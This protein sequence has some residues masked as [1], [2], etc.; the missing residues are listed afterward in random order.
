MGRNYAWVIATLKAPSFCVFTLWSKNEKQFKE[1]SF[2]KITFV[3]LL[4]LDYRKNVSIAEMKG[5]IKS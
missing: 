3:T 4:R 1:N 2:A 5:G